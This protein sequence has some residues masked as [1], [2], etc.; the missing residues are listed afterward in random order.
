MKSTD[1]REVT[2]ND[3]RKREFQ[4]KDPADYEFRGDGEV[5][6]KDRWEEAIH[7]IRYILGDTRRDFEVNDIVSAVEAL[8]A[9]IPR[10]D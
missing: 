2:E 8:V 1:K 6:R 7:R 5:V 3:F 10:G 4:G 9:T